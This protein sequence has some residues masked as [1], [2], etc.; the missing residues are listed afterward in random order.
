MC[1][2]I[3]IVASLGKFGGSAVA[4]RITGLN[5][6]DSSALGVLMNTRGLMEL[7]VLN[8]GLEMNVISPTLFAMLAIMALI[9]TFSTTPILALITRRQ[10]AT[11]E[12]FPELGTFSPEPT[13]ALQ[14]PILAPHPTPQSTPRLQ[15]PPRPMPVLTHLST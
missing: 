13:V 10:D 9:T 8:I 6:R 11:F 15:L 7:I 3:V 1:A 2:L 12:P 4:A 14:P 5:W